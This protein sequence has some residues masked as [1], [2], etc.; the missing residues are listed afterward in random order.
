M[1][2]HKLPKNFP[3]KWKTNQNLRYWLSTQEDQ[4]T[5][6]D[7]TLFISEETCVEFARQFADK[8]PTCD[9]CKQYDTERYLGCNV[10][11]L[12]SEAKLRKD[13]CNDHSGLKNE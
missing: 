4:E 5:I 8:H 9:T 6:C 3:D 13:Y 12:T 7:E 10:C 11:D 2:K 1:K